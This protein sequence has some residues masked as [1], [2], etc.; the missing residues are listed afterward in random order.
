MCPQATAAEVRAWY[1]NAARLEPVI[2]PGR[3]LTA[4]ERAGVMLY[5]NLVDETD[6]ELIAET[7]ERCRTSP[8]ALA[9]FVR[10]GE[11]LL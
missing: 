1:P 7:L 5:L 2:D 4:D 11:E 6:A 10:A 8:G 9:F 3:E